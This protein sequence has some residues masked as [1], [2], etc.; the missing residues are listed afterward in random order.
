MKQ[1]LW[2]LL[3]FLYSV[4]AVAQKAEIT[5]IITDSETNEPIPGV[6]VTLKNQDSKAVTDKTGKFTLQN[7][8][9][10]SDELIVKP[11]MNQPL[12]MK[13]AVKNNEQ[14]KLGKIEY[15]FP[16]SISAEEGDNYTFSESQIEE[17]NNTRQRVSILESEADDI[18]LK[19]AR[20]S[21]SP[22]RFSYRGY[23][24]D[25]SSTYINGVGFNDGERGRFNYSMLGGLNNATKNKDIVTGLKANPF[26]FGGLG[27]NTNILTKAS[28]YAA[29]TRSSISY[30]NRS[31][32][33]R[34]QVTNA[35]GLM[36]NGWA[37]T[38]SAVVRWA[39]EGLVEG[40][41]YK[42]AGYYFSAEKIL[43]KQHSFSFVTFGAP[44]QRAGSA[45]VTQEVY[46]LAGSIYYNPYWGYQ[47]GKKRNSRIV[48]S[49]DPTA[50]FSHEFKIDQ[51]Q[52]L[53]T[54][55][56]FHYS[57]YSNSALT[58]YNAPDPRP[59]YYRLLPSFFT[60][61]EAK[62][63]V[64]NLW[65]TDPSVSQINWNQL[66]QDNYKNN[67]TDPAASAK[68]AVERRHNNLMEAT[69]NSTY[70][71]QKSNELKVTAGIEAK[72]S[73]GMHY[74][75]MDDLLGGK[76]WI[77]IDQFA[78]RDNPSNPNVI[79]NDL[80]NPNRVIKVG[81]K[82]GYNYN[83]N[84][85]RAN[86]FYQREWSFPGYDIYYAGK[87]AYQQFYR[88]GLMDNGRALPTV[89]DPDG[90]ISYG[91]GKT[92]WF[93][94]PSFK[95]GFTCKSDGHNRVS[96][97]TLAESRAPLANNSYISQR[98][99]DSKIPN[100][101][102]EKIASYDLSYAFNYPIIRGKFSAF[103]T[104][105]YG[106][107]EL[108]GYYDDELRTFVN[109]VLTKS[110]K[111]YQ[112]VEG[113]LSLKINSQV[114]LS[115]AGTLADY[116]YTN[117]AIGI[118]SPENGAVPDVTEKIL[119]SGLKESTGP[120]LATNIKL[121]YF[122]PKMWFADVSFN[123]F[124]NNYLDFAPSRFSAA[125]VSKYAATNDPAVKAALGTQEKLKGGYMIDASLGKLI[126]MPHGQSLNFNLSVSNLLNNTK[127]VTGGYQQARLPLSNGALE[128]DGLNRFPSK[129]YYAWGVNVFFNIGY[130]F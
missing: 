16:K 53:R 80:R 107:S 97:N 122:H 25:Y 117:D 111:V 43:N 82:F 12:F 7:V 34:A 87:V 130:K 81:D 98:I 32:K 105:T 22:M 24:Q 86:A 67:A 123:Y 54:G 119:T 92:W 59:D 121:N 76:Q 50:I 91:K 102:S 99:K 11:K 96:F 33:L 73:K 115:M 21:F 93:V 100:L 14:K 27:S 51:K 38:T 45:A 129:Y 78:E 46:D 114:T 94:D 36:A 64:T 58:F 103:Q 17:D 72:I 30:T 60:T 52:T 88:E 85:I 108:F 35:T 3:L 15:T 90:D 10:G 110:D 28:N 118:K 42:S 101:Q 124:D 1:K 55:L 62:D 23:N 109:Q 57:L 126:Y 37:F 40:T 8:K 9:P 113:A 2:I 71:N 69:L 70:T 61:Q 29:G 89:N 74:K 125:N 84:V 4:A 83:L 56:G 6:S 48:N 44:T 5:G 26:S 104:F 77:D 112:G 106:S 128:L 19:S 63:E 66:Y 31:Y 49:F 79:Q 68:Y 13:V 127:M 120:Q 18:Y 39:D 20:F 47:D 75:T 65:K 116:H 95:F 41:F